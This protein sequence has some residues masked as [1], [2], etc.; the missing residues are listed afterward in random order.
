VTD[1]Q[2]DT[3]VVVWLYAGEHDRI[4][5]GIRERLAVEPLRVSPTV[6]MELTYLHEIGRLAAPAARILDE[7]EHSIALTEDATA[8]G[9]VVRAAETLTWTRDP[10]DR[11]IAAQ[12]LVSFSTLVTKDDN[13]R[14]ALG[15]YAVWD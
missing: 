4:P 6:R 2:L 7:L 1:L 5:A 13:I 8:F 3:H 14:Q 15:T 10:F 9:A 11:L 12:A